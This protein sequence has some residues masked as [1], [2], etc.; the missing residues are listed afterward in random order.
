VDRTGRQDRP[1]D[2][3]AEGYRAAVNELP[4]DAGLLRRRGRIDIAYQLNE[5]L[6]RALRPVDEAKDPDDERE[7]RDEREEQLVSD[8]AREERAFVFREGCGD[9]ARV[10]D[11]CPDRCQE[12][13]SLFDPPSLFDAGFSGA[14]VS[15]FLS[16]FVSLLVS[17]FVSVLVSL[18]LSAL[19]S[20]V[21]S[22]GRL[23][24]L[25]QPEPLK[26]I[27]GV[28]MSRRGFLPQLGHFSSA[29][30]LNDCTAE[31]TWPQ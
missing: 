20:E 25:Y 22:A 26:T 8:R 10:A 31:N 1:D 16:A 30:S 12:A 6:L 9:G 28:E 24:V 11:D 7:E 21:L 2:A 14:F 4:R 19:A 13:A 5:L 29:S 17:V 3:N 18:F 15:L 27:A 23:S